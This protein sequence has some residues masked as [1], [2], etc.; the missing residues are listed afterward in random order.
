MRFTRVRLLLF[1]TLFG[2]YIVIFALLYLATATGES[3]LTNY[4]FFAGSGVVCGFS[5]TACPDISQAK[6]GSTIELSGEGTFSLQAKS[7]FGS[8]SYTRKAASGSI[9]GTGTWTAY[10][11]ISFKSYGTSLNLPSDY[12]GGLAKFRLL[13]R[14]TSGFLGFHALL[15]VECN[16]GRP[17]ASAIEGITLTTSGKG[18]NFSKKISGSTL[19][20]RN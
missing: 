19:F 3:A 17:P 6:D 4:Q 5:S 13:L 20:V 8:G 14:P 12:E 16:I 7:A 11:L 9:I 2:S 1:T 10:E 15:E 18:V